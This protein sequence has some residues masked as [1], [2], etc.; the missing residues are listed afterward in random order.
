MRKLRTVYP[1][2]L[3][4]RTGDEYMQEKDNDNI[5]SKFPSLIRR[6]DWHKTRTKN[7]AS[8]TFIVDQFI[9][10][11]NESLCTNIINTINLIRV[12]L[13]SLK[14][15]QCRTLIDRIDDYLSAK[16]DNYPY[17]QFFEAAVTS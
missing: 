9:Y 6:K 15:S 1:F 17:F 16:H 12:L 5:F 2:G 11:I 10:I 14:K 8:N 4:A 3:N 13:T 7:T